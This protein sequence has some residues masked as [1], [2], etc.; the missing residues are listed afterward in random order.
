M[1]APVIDVSR[2]GRADPVLAAAVEL[3]RA[4]VVEEASAAHVGEHLGCV[5]GPDDSAEAPLALHLFACRTASYS[6]WLWSVALTRLADE[7]RVTVDE[8][9]L[10]PGED[11]LLPPE[12]L[13]W[14]Q[15]LRGDDLGVGDLLPTDPDDDRL[16]P[17]YVATGDPAVDDVAYELG[18][19]R[20]RV[21]SRSGRLEAAERWWEGPTG[22][23]SPMARQAP[24]R[25][26]DCGF[27]LTLDG[28]LR[29]LLGVCGNEYAPS[30]GRIV[31]VEYGCGA[32]SE[33]VPEPGPE[34]LNAVS[35]DTLTALT[36]DA[37][38]A[39]DAPAE[40]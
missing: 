27:Y 40:S 10:Q 2:T 15:R 35:Y 12:W 26:G 5:P 30:D 31:A 37:A 36:E 4:A 16:V 29:A 39:P 23:D 14:R 6:G 38:V 1:S 8:V 34:P 20:V 21:M 19:G 32:H 11:A 18:L 3:A 7:D 22:P 33:A 24:G 9:A 28:S 17:A 25:C 13:P